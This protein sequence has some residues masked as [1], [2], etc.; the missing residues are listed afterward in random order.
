MTMFNNPVVRFDPSN[1]SAFGTLESQDLTPVIQGDFVYGLNTQVWQTPV[2]S[3]TGATVDTNASRLRI[4]SGTANNGYAYV[5]SRRAVRYR[6]GQGTVARF[7]PL[8]TTGV[9]DSTQL[10]GMGTVASNAPLDGYFFGYN[11]ATFGICHYNNGSPTWV[12]QAD[13]N[14]DKVNGDAG[15]AFTLNPTYGTPAMIKYPYLGY[16]DIEFF[17]QNPATGRWVLAHVIRYANTTATIQLTNPSMH[18]MGYV[19]NSGNVANLTLYCGSVGVFISGQRSFISCSRWAADSNKAS[20]T[21]ETALL[22]IRAATTYNGVTNRAQIRFN[23]I[24]FAS[25]AATSNSYCI[26]RAYLNPTVGGTPAWAT[27]SGTSADSGVT[28]TSGQSVA[29]ID[30]AGTLSG[31][32]YLFNLSIASGSNV[33]LDL[34]PFHNFLAP[35]EIMGFTGTASSNSQLG[36]SVNWTEDQ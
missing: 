17:L 14:G 9:A 23:S 16:G 4:Q 15:T 5:L 32:T 8:F 11:G 33:V 22:A 21:T 29:S 6:A 28:I 2:T 1:M 19:K 25:A 30:K 18:F 26:L 36:V 10:W 7:T 3:G 35:G 27:I 31:G 34:T 20:I 13:W 24:S 12:A